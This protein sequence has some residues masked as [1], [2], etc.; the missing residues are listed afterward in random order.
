YR[1]F[2]YA[3]VEL[4]QVVHA[5]PRDL[6]DSPER[7]HV[8]NYREGDLPS[9]QRCYRASTARSTGPLERSQRWWEWRGLRDDQDRVVS[10][11]PGSG[12]IEGYVLGVLAEL[13]PL[14]RRVFRVQELIASTRRA[15]LGLRGWLASLADEFATIEASLPADESW[16]P[17]LRDPH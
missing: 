12:R 7:R 2:G 4:S 13:A 1:R 5:R 14:G 17:F 10:A 6:P 15:C 8:R 3:P 11:A 16:L 9:L